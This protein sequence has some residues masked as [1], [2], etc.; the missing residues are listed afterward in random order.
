MEPHKDDLEQTP[1]TRP[2]GKKRRFRLVKLE[3]HRFR[4]DRLE[5]RIAPT[6]IGGSAKPAP[7]GHS[8]HTYIH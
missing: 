1:E 5:E 6:L 2:E 4:M 7:S 3:E 8:N